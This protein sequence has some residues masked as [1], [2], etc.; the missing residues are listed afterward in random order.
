MK[1]VIL[2]NI[3]QN[4]ILHHDYYFDLETDP[5]QKINFSNCQI[6]LIQHGHN[7][8]QNVKSVSDEGK[9]YMQPQKSFFS[10]VMQILGKIFLNH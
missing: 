1:R 2:K 10:I 7:N 9:N 3:Y 6:N 4:S 8:L 5:E